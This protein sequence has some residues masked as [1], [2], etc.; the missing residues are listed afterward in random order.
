MNIDR[1]MHGCATFKSGGKTYAI[2]AGGYSI[3]QG[4][5][6]SVEFLDLE[7]NKGWQMSD[8]RL[9]KAI[10]R[11]IMVAGLDFRTVYLIG[12]QYEDI[13]GDYI[14]SDISYLTCSD[15]EVTSCQFAPLT[16]RVIPGYLPYLEGYAVIPI[17]ESVLDG[18][19]EENS[20][21][22]FDITEKFQPM[23]NWN[24]DPNDEMTRCL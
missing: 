18:V 16:T 21:I 13:E 14:S 1:Y 20:E 2:V 24:E 15:S 11:H 23:Y 6:S 10:H 3:V 8:K 17:P 7:A 5:M 19:S 22:E 12:G 4:G 9:P